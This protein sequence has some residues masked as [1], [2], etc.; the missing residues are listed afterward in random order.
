MLPRRVLELNKD[1]GER[2]SMKEPD[3]LEAS[4]C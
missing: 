2:G 4:R 1:A 3:L